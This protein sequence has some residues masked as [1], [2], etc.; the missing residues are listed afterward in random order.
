M[1]APATKQEATELAP[2][3]A[4]QVLESKE[5]PS[6]AA[7][8]G[9]AGEVSVDRAEGSASGADALAAAGGASP[10][11]VADKRLEPILRKRGWI[12]FG[13]VTVLAVALVPI[14]NSLPTASA[15][16]L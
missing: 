14:L 13:V 16:H 12:A 11:A 4:E 15:L 6:A 10:P 5:A 8:E 7:G 2:P 9:A 1:S 3:S